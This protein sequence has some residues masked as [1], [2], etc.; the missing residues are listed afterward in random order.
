MAIGRGEIPTEGIGWNPRL[1]HRGMIVVRG[2]HAGAGAW[3]SFQRSVGADPAS[4]FVTG[5]MAIWGGG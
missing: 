3:A 1:L 5:D 4:D 2:Q